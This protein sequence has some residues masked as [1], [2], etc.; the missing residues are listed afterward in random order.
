MTRMQ[1]T[2][3]FQAGASVHAVAFA[4]LAG[5]LHLPP[6]GRETGRGDVGVVI[7]SP[8]GRDARCAHL[9]M[10]L[11]AERLA[12]AGIATLRYDHADTGDSRDL[13]PDDDAMPVW[14]DGIARAQAFLREAAAVRRVVLCGVRLGASLAAAAGDEADGLVL[15]APVVS[16]RSWV[17]RLRF[18]ASAG[19]GAAPKDDEVLDSDGLRLSA[20]TARS[21]AEL[22]LMRLDPPRAPVLTLAH[23]HVS[24]RYIRRLA[25]Q[26]AQ[27]T[28]TDFPGYE[29]LFLD[30]HRNEAPNAA[31]DQALGW[32]TALAERV[33]EGGVEAIRSEPVALG[34]PTEG[35]PCIPDWME[36]T[37]EV[38]HDGAL[39]R[40][41]RFGAE[42]SGV[43]CAPAGPVRR[44]GDGRAVL[45]CNTG[46]DPR[47][48]LGRFATLS[49]RALARRGVASLRFDFAG[50]GDSPMTS[51]ETR[52]HVYET[53]RA[54]DLDAAVELMQAQGYRR[55]YVVGVCAGAYHALHGALRD[56]RITG[57]LAIS[58]AKL[59][60]RPGDSLE[61]DRI[62]EGRATRVYFGRM[63]DPRTWLRLMQGGI[64]V[65]AVAHYIRL[66]LSAKW[67]AHRDRA[68]ARLR[69]E[70]AALSARGGRAC[71]LMG[72]DDASLDEVETYFGA[73]GK[74]FAA[75]AGMSVHITPGLDH[76]LARSTSRDL[77]FQTLTAWLDD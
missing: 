59:I 37:A 55:L 50:L 39:E 6:S 9:P 19:A 56:S 33:V 24:D 71:L 22:D 47:A 14:R 21:L 62:D 30:T 69:R 13:A 4:G 66:R 57:A 43:L 36:H 76:G 42:L 12:A 23:G 60:W 70:V 77:A 49:A 25:E 29:A 48:G 15:F 58:P 74:R 61:P 38:E 73:F 11:F 67:A 52:S 68:A 75:L 32:L 1:G 44:R 35:A 7:C 16:G 28:Q 54:A 26:G 18:A 3:S 53:P 17:R 34:A 41:V 63:G 65:P 46:G 64:D 10:R 5:W 8:L 20:A 40:A 31:F 27:L 45:F 51:G 2:S 72:T